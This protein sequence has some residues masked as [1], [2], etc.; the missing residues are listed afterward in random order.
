MVKFHSAKANLV[1]FYLCG[2]VTPS[3][4]E[5]KSQKTILWWYLPI[6]QGILNFSSGLL[7]KKKR[8][9][10]GLRIFSVEHRSDFEDIQ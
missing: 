8:P 1:P 6:P 7:K 3:G 10:K 5:G 9:Q 2:A 4:R